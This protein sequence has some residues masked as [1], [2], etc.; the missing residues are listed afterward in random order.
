M[1]TTTNASI[2]RSE[3]HVGIDIGK[4]TLDLCIY[5]VDIYH[6]FPNNSEGIKALAKML[7]F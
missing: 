1:K 3:P 7:A 5:E 2:N 4:S 6:Q